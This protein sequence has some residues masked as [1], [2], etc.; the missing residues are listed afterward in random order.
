MI[1]L[2]NLSKSY[3][4]GELFRHVNISIKHGMRLGLVGPNGSGKTTLLKIFLG[5]ESPDSGNVQIEKSTTIGYLS[6]EIVPSTNRSILEEVL[7]GYPEVGELEGK[8]LSLSDA[9][10]K[11]PQN[12]SLANQLGDVQHRFEALGGWNLED[13][14]KKILSGLGFSEKQL[15]DP[16][17]VFSGGWRMRVALAA[18]LLQEPDILFLDE[19]TN[20][21]DLEATIW[22]ESFLSEWKGGLILISHDR[23]FLDRSVNYILEIEL[24][25]VT[26]YKGNYSQYRVEKAVRL[27][28]HK[29]AY[30]NQQKQIKDTEKFIERFR[31]KNTKATQVHSR[32]KMLNKMEKIVPPEENHRAMN[33][34]LPES[35]RPPLNLITCKN[36]V[37]HYGETEVFDQLNLVIERGQKIGLLGPN[38]AGKSTLLKLLAD[39]EKVTSGA[40][41]TGSKV[42]KAYFAQH[43]LEVL[44]PE[45]TV[46]ESIRN[47]SPGWSETQVRS[48]LGNF[49]FIK[50]TVEKLVKILSGGEK[51]RLA[52]ARMLIEPAH[53]LL[54]DEPTNH[55]DMVSRSV[56]ENIL[57]I[58]KGA[59]VCIS[60]DRHF[61]NKVTHLTCEIGGG[62]IRMFEGNYDY[63]IWKKNQELAPATKK[64]KTKQ[65]SK[66]KRD[67]QESKKIR[68]RLAWIERRFN[69]IETSL[70]KERAITQ[71]PDYVHQY[72]ILQEALE[73]MN[74]LENE[75]LALME[76]QEAL[77]AKK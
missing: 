43:Q 32:I 73:N 7:A 35:G 6:Q 13:K 4:D 59:V 9:V 65:P 10:T 22:L 17:E 42:K 20:H 46:Y 27:E 55:L 72:E 38:G 44:D 28:H 16:M 23:A 49:L 64:L 66:R 71:N 61:L 47:V 56:V 75:Y 31:Y 26:L 3:P 45:S 19:P 8:M 58:F 53:V 77:M 40:V 25:R 52:L 18:I 15:M 24:K 67:Y 48:Y 33:I 74:K 30:N 69:T 21:L 70:E 57:T 1:R 14:A 51:S 76:E 54:L 39:V 2:E 34:V 50:G 29:A 60:H 37:K 68:N 36:V 11:N 5:M 63:Y 62:S 12:R 41:R